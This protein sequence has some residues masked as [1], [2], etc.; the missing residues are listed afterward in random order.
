MPKKLILL[1]GA[2]G[3]GKT[4]DAKLIAEKHEGSFTSYS[5]GDLIR[6]EVENE[7]AIGK[8]AKDF[9]AKGDLVPTAIVVEMIVAAVKAAPTEIVL[10]DGFPGKEKQMQHFCDF[11]FSNNGIKLISVIEVRVNEEVA[12]ERWLASGKDEDIFRHE[13]SAYTEA[14][15]VIEKHYEDKNVLKIIDGEKDLEAVVA[16]IDTFLVSKL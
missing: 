12:K 13:M 7:T 16:E 5:T 10:L 11:L 8:I 3:S 9:V 2:P 15:S 4:T 1:I 14:I 6:K